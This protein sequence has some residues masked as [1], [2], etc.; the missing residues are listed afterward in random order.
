ME[1]LF[2]T[3]KYPPSTGGMEKQSYE[4][5]NGMRRYAV[6]HVI[7]PTPG[8]SKLRFFRLLRQRIRAMRQQHPGIEW[9][10]FNDALIA[11][12]GTR[13]GDAGG[14]S[15]AVTVHGLDVV[16]PNRWYQRFVLPRFNRF[17]R[18]IAVS[19]ATADA[20]VARGLDPAKVSVVLN[21][22]DHDIAS[23]P[24]STDWVARHGLNPEQPILVAMGRSVRRKGF[25]WLVTEV[26]PRLPANVQLL[27]IGPFSPTPTPTERWLSR[28]PGSLRRQIG[29]ALGFPDDEVALRRLLPLHPNVRHLGRLPFDEVVA[30]FRVARA[31]V[32]PN[33]AVAGDM[34]G[35]G[36]VCLEASLGGAPVFAADLDGIPSAILDGK[37]GRLLPSANADVWVKALTEAIEHPQAYQRLSREWQAYSLAHYS[38]ER[39]VEGYLLLMTDD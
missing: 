11:A 38:W 34:E 6:V 22:V 31:F 37:N 15:R 17:D 8:E 20:C 28:L 25:S 36:L 16:F 13:S 30:I 29:L 4:L 14:V 33:I 32:M 26:M 39:M 27:F 5:I 1:I 23:M 12:I 24:A 7:A 19:E 21:G 35:F 18:I 10:H 9:I 3:H 2:V